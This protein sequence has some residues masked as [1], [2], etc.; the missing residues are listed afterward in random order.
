VAAV[1]VL[2][3]KVAVIRS[4]KGGRA[5]PYLGVSLFTLLAIT[6]LTVTPEFLAGE[7]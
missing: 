4:G 1:V 6:W 7:D 2:A 5:L 3:I